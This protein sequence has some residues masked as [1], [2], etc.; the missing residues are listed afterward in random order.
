MTI[1]WIVVNIALAVAVT[2]FVAG[3]SVLVPLQLD[4]RARAPA[5]VNP[6]LALFGVAH[7]Q[8]QRYERSRAA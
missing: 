7:R 3:I 8:N 4:R 6:A 5:P 1:T 2:A